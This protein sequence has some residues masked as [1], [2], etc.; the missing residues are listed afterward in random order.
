[1]KSNKKDHIYFCN[2]MR[3]NKVRKKFK[4]ILFFLELL[5][6]L[7]KFKKLKKIIKKH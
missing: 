2:T 1:M 7:Q 4:D 5:K 6:L 3:K